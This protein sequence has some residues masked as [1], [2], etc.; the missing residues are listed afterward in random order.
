M[1]SALVNTFLRTDIKADV[2]QVVNVE[3]TKQNLVALRKFVAIFISFSVCT[4][5][6]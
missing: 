5:L 6:G 3:W 1:T 2:V 4:N